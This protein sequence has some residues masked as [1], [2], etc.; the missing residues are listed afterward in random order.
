[1]PV[2]GALP[3]SRQPELLGYLAV[4]IESLRAAQM[5]DLARRRCVEDASL[6]SDFAQHTIVAGN[7]LGDLLGDRPPLMAVRDDRPGDRQSWIDTFPEKS[8]R[9]VQVDQSAKL[10]PARLDDNA[11]VRR[12]G[13]AVDR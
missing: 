10:E 9:L 5:V 6:G 8:N 12:G 11:N 7:L 4:I 1:M 2:M 3:T 13:K